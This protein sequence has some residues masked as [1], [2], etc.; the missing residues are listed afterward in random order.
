MIFLYLQYLSMSQSIH[1]SIYLSIYLSYYYASK[2]SGGGG[3]DSARQVRRENLRNQAKRAMREPWF[4]LKSC[5]AAQTT[6]VNAKRIR[7]Y[8][9]RVISCCDECE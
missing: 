7:A 2:P 3:L 9:K 5:E 6:G 8:T 1:P 4:V